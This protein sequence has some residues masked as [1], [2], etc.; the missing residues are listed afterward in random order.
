[1][2]QAKAACAVGK[3]SSIYLHAEIAALVKLKDW[4][5][6]H[7]MVIFRYAKA[8]LSAKDGRQHQGGTPLL[9]KPCSICQHVINQTGIKHVEY[10]T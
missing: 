6:A 8:D 2:V 5:K 4:D 7:K 10:T 3:P 1:M 9:A